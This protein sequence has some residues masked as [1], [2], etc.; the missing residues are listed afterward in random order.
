MIKVKNFAFTAYPVTDLTRARK[1]Y[2]GVL[3][4]KP[5]QVFGEGDQGWIEYTIGDS[6]LAISNMASDKWQPSPQGPSIAFE[7]EDFPV[8][9]AELKAAGA[10]L[11]AEPMESPAC[12]FA[13]FTDL[14]GN[15]FMVHKLKH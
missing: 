3:N 12:W 15:G 6:T 1:F 14:D 2:E 10:F 4:L 7:V 5:T 8:S 13:V 11:C 9:V